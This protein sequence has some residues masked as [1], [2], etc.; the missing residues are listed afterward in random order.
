MKWILPVLFSISCPSKIPAQHIINLYPG[1]APGSESWSHKE[2]SDTN[3]M[4]NQIMVTNVVHPS[5][6]VFKPVHPNG[7]AMIICPGGAFRALSMGNEGTDVAKFLISK[8]IT[9]FVLKYRLVPEQYG[10]IQQA[11]QDIQTNNFQRIDSINNPFV[12]MAVADGLE[13][14]R[15]LRQHATEFGIHPHRIGIMGFSAGGTLSASV[16]YTYDQNS[17]PDFVAPIY[18]Y[19]PAILGHLV[20]ADAPPLFLLFAE[21]DFIADDNPGLYQKWKSAG[22]SAELHAYPD[23]GHGFGI[24]KQGLSTDRWEDR[25]VDWMFYQFPKQEIGAYWK[26]VDY[27]GDS[28]IGHKLDIHLPFNTPGPY[29]VVVGIYGSAWFSNSAKANVYREGLGQKLLQAGYAVVSINH[30]SSRDAKFPAQIQDVKAAIRFMRA[31]ARKY[32]IDTSFVGITGWSSGGHLSALA[33]TTN[34]IKKHKI[35][36]EE[37]DIEGQLGSFTKASSKVNAVVD[38]YGPTDFLI[39]DSCGSVFQHNGPYS[40]ES[41]LLGG[42]IQNNKVKATLA[43]PMTYINKNNPPFLILH[44][45]KDGDVPPCQSEKLFMKLKEAKIKSELV[46]VPGAGHGPG[47]LID[48][49]FDK[50]ISF[51]NRESKKAK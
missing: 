35:N 15:Y 45:D 40:P 9:A 12:P 36:N 30:R 39:I 25:L 47:V 8:G 5:L 24:R 37:A 31:N 29:P 7:M 27:V 51:F 28:I 22:R 21:N 13:A 20:P 49:Y 44:G 10:S 14:I 50:M 48:T 18:A 32:N 43:N 41:F 26:D 46:L 23:G 19:C 2:K 38:W 33:G 11:F 34:D 3:K 6:T 16:A 42:P 1:P 17:R 4:N